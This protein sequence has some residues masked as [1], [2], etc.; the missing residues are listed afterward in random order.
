VKS[1]QVAVLP[2][3]GLDQTKVVDNNEYTTTAPLQANA[4]YNPAIAVNGATAAIDLTAAG[5]VVANAYGTAIVDAAKCNACHDALGT[6]FHGPNYGS[7]GV[8]GCR[9]CHWVGSGSSH[10]EMQSRSIDSFVHAV[11]SMQYFDVKNVDLTNAIQSLRYGDHVEGNYPNFAGTLNCESCHVKGTYDVPDQARSLPGI[12]SAAQ[13]LKGGSRNIGT[14]AA[15]ITG[16]AAR[17][18]GG[19]HRAQLI[20]EDDASSLAAFYAHTADFGSAVSDTTQ[21]TATTAYLMSQIG[22]AAASPAVAGAQVESCVICH[23]TAGSDH[24][25]L[26][27]TWQKGL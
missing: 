14:V 12:L 15:E 16:P 18:C 22:V 13:V 7:A 19:C 27:N 20:N 6:T 25:A 26:F 24:Q 3:I 10:L 2:S 5:A 23:P 8:V 21:L 9:V 17:A 1:V 11:H 4:N